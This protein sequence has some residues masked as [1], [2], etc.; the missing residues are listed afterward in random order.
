M[1]QL[2]KCCPCS[3]PL[4]VPCSAIHWHFAPRIIIIKSPRLAL[5]L[6]VGWEMAAAAAFIVYAHCATAGVEL[7]LACSTVYTVHT[8]SAAFHSQRGPKFLSA[9]LSFIWQ[10]ETFECR[11][12]WQPAGRGQTGRGWALLSMDNLLQP[13]NR[14]SPVEALAGLPAWNA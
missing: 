12:E 6:S 14:R 4:S 8:Q 13:Q 10:C 1:K 3:V 7:K 9:N 11:V 5:T 2:D